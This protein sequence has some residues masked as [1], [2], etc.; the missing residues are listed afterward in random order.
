MNTGN[1]FRIVVGILV[2]GLTSCNLSTTETRHK[3]DKNPDTET[4]TSTAM[5]KVQVAEFMHT[6]TYTYLLVNENNDEYWIAI[7]KREVKEGDTY[8]YKG[9]YEMKKFESRELGRTFESLRL[10]EEI[11]EGPGQ[12]PPAMMAQTPGGKKAAIKTGAIT[13]KHEKGE[14]PLSAIFENP[15]SYADK[16]ITVRGTVVK[17]NEKIM[18]KNWVHI[19][20]GTESGGKFDLTI[21]TMGLPSVGAIIGFEGIIRTN[22]DFGAGYRYDVIME[23]AEMVTATI[24]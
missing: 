12:T 2:I 17:V 22:K 19:Q 11:S 14:T 16:K 20:D 4:S 5:H 13:I 23:D 21:T 6:S 24:L 10:V 1:L 9:G 7:P 15:E 18:G 3:V 8:Y